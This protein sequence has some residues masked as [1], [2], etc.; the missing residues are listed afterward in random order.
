M[1]NPALDSG[2]PYIELVMDNRK[3][4]SWL[5]YDATNDVVGMSA[6]TYKTLKEA[7]LSL[8]ET[9][10]IFAT[11]QVIYYTNRKVRKEGGFTQKRLDEI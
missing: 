1:T 10:S 3:R 2:E 5:V 4:W 6:I 8:K 9:R 11:K 7:A